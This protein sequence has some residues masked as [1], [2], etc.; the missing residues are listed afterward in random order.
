MQR[1]LIN[2]LI[3]D[4]YTKPYLIDFSQNYIQQ[5]ANCFVDI[6]AIESAVRAR[7]GRGGAHSYLHN[8]KAL[9]SRVVGEQTENFVVGK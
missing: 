1:E 2:N 7:A 4:L 9:H 5:N 3:Y 8:Y 6:Y